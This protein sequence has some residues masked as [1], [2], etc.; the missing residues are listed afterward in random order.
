MKAASRRGILMSVEPR[1]D[2]DAEV[3][4]REWRDARGEH[5]YR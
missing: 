3:V 2:A 4:E 1:S 5:V